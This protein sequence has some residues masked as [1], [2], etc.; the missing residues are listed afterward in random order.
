MRLP[1][2]R[3]QRRAF[4]AMSI[5]DIRVAGLNQHF[6]TASADQ[7]YQPSRGS[8]PAREAPRQLAQGA[9]MNTNNNETRK[10]FNIEWKPSIEQRN[11]DMFEFLYLNG[12]Y[13]GILC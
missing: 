5:L 12:N 6:S 13:V 9:Q 1:V 10:L 4:S 7:L 2:V 8:F 11:D 3:P